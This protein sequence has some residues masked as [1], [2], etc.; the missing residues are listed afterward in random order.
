MSV[1][2]MN[3][4][5]LAI[6][7]G[8]PVRKT[9]LPYGHQSIAEDDIAAVVNVLR[10][11]WLT[12]GPKIAEFEEAFAAEV[13]ARYAVSFSSGTAALHGAAFAAGLKPGDEAI[14][15]PMTFAATAN[16]VLYQDA[17][18]VFA[19]VSA[20]TLNLS[21]EKLVER[22]TPR[23]RAILAVDYA[24]HPADM[25]SIHELAARH[26][27]IVIEDASHALGAEYKGRRVG[28]IADMTV[29]SFHPVKHLTTGEG[30]MVTTNR[31]DFAETLRRFRNH[32][33]SSDARQR[34]A[35][36][37]WHYEMVLL[38][39]NYRLTDIAC[40]L[41]LSQLKRLENNLARRREIAARYTAA[42]RDLLG[43]RTP[44]VRE[45]LNP[46]WHLYPIRLNPGKTNR[47]SCPDFPRPPRRKYRCQRS[48]HSRASSSLLSQPLRI[49]RRRISRRRRS[50]RASDQSPD[51]SWHEPSGCGRRDCGGKESHGGVFRMSA[52]VPF[53]QYSVLVAGAGSIGRRHMTNL[54][55]LGIE[56]LA[57][58]DPDAGRL[59]PIL[60]ELNAEGFA[61]IDTALLNFKPDVVFICT[62]PVFHVQQASKA[63]RGGADVFIEK[64][65]SHSL[66]C[67]D[68]LKAEAGRL[69]RVVH[70][71]Y[72]LRFHRGI[73]ILKRLI[74]EGMAGRILWARAEV[75][76][77]LPDWRPWQD[78]RQS[79]TA[80]R[81][82]GGGIILDASHEIDYILWLLGPPSELTCMAGQVSGLDVNVEDCA[83]I[84]IRLRSGA[85]ADIHMDFVQ[86]TAS[87]FCVIAGERARLEWNYARNEVRLIRPNGPPEVMSYEFETNQMYVRE[88]E[89]FFC[90]VHN[91]D[92]RNRE[93]AESQLTLEVALAALASASGQRWVSFEK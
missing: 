3:R 53:T 75:A 42:F 79:Y 10:S 90:C 45:N 87:R 51:V 11:D 50:L 49:S 23:T 78:Y 31:P 39:F 64:P 88:V 81:E 8:T 83:T 47:Q 44:V 15:T 20:D 58:V 60:K 65:L 54:R 6:D 1:L 84:L 12:T 32:G 35:E 61:D 19:D 9:L 67:V 30:G 7:G 74:E 76:Q 41:G 43:I 27:C 93:L 38:G 77:Y 85:Q 37:Q 28:S 89:E 14:T 2:P 21:P 62:P 71:G 55:Q 34:Q 29:F 26:G 16:C 73:Q 17:T 48:L 80:R 72:N 40:A 25:D 70:V 18:P 92:T 4:V 91:R 63:V 52:A 24:G 86:R 36:G 82:L 59:E 66:D 57:G 46:A 22:I 68:A 13:S 5:M 56:R 69:K 33:I